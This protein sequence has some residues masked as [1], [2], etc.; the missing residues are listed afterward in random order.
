M[1][2]GGGAFAPLLFAAVAAAVTF[3]AA[4][5]YRRSSPLPTSFTLLGEKLLGRQ[6]EEEEGLE[7]YLRFEKERL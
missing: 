1:P 7:P 5:L 4:R 3:G 2:A 6:R